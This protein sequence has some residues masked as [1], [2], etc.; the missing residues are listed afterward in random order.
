MQR[1]DIEKTI[2]ESSTHYRVL[3]ARTKRRL[4]IDISKGTFSLQVL[5]E[6]EQE[7]KGIMLQLFYFVFSFEERDS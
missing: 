4:L 5:K 2:P 3:A 1:R 7:C 6:M